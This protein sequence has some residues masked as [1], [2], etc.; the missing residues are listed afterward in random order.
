MELP[1]RRLS[2]RLGV[3]AVA[4]AASLG[5]V[6]GA[7]GVF[8]FVVVVVM[9]VVVG[10]AIQVAHLGVPG[11]TPVPRH[12]V[13]EPVGV[14][15]SSS[16]GGWLMAAVLLRLIIVPILNLS[17]MWRAFAPDAVYWSMTG[18]VVY[19]DWMG[20]S[21]G[22]DQLFG[23][24][25]TI[26]FYS[27]LNAAA[28]AVFDENRITMSFINSFTGLA[29]AFVF[30]QLAQ[31]LHGP[32]VARLSFIMI[33]LFPSLVL[34]TSMNI[35]EAW[36]LLVIALF[37]LALFRMRRSFN[38]TSTVLLVMC[39]CWMSIIRG[40]LVPLLVV[41]GMTSLVVV[42]L[43]HVPYALFALL[44]MVLFLRIYGD[45]LG[46]GFELVSTETL[47]ETDKMRHDL[48]YGGSA[49]GDDVDTRT[50]ASAIAYLPV[51]TLYF[52]SL[53]FPWTV[54]SALQAMT[55]PESIVW[56]V[57]LYYASR[58]LV[59]SLRRYLQDAAGMIFTTMLIT[60]GYGLVSGN[61]GTAYR[62]RAQILPVFIIFAAS[63]LVRAFRNQRLSGRA[64][65]AAP[66]LPV[67]TGAVAE[68]PSAG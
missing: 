18:H 65:E 32:R 19:E 14:H 16:I 42:R 12:S 23:E 38:V 2:D 30:A 41:G 54:S 24:D 25:G 6:F 67:T 4:V 17:P 62:H 49:Y 10:R 26:P 61:G 1:L 40:Y 31:E 33:A 56:Y 59:F 48:A 57:L 64:P 20:Q 35:R 3:A 43:R 34:W 55:V 44:V 9:V 21:L 15:F 13:V 28:Y 68:G 47:K 7:Y 53:P 27:I 58:E 29:A 60:L 36:S 39:I 46:I 50:L 8:S 45:A 5:F 51:G 37:H 63:A 22:V 52:L 11:V 66:A